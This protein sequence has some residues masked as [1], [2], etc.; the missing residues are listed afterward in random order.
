MKPNAFKM[1]LNPSK[2]WSRV[3][4]LKKSSPIPAESGVYACYFKQVPAIIPKQDCHQHNKFNLLYVGIAP[5]RPSSS[6][7]LRKRIKEHYRGN[8]FGST[9]RL[10]LGCL[11][12][13]DKHLALEKV[14]YPTGWNKTPLSPEHN[15]LS[16][17][18]GG[19]LTHPAAITATQF[20]RQRKPSL[21]STTNRNSQPSQN[22]RKRTAHPKLK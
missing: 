4:V 10:S 9:L 13:A 5:S 19:H 2:L 16:L 20:T 18:F 15:A 22:T 17:D 12:A 1:L 14:H 7:D 8:A 3:E 21:S 6:N 11:L